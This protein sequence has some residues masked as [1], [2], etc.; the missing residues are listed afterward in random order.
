MLDRMRLRFWHR[1]FRFVLICQTYAVCF[2]VWLTFNKSTT[3]AAL[4]LLP[5]FTAWAMTCGLMA[6]HHQERRLDGNEETRP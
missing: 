2:F 5:C 6:V 1:F 4:L 3:F